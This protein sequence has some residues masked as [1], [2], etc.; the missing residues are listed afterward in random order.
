MKRSKKWNGFVNILCWNQSRFK[1]I[2]YRLEV[3]E[4]CLEMFGKLIICRVWYKSE[5]LRRFQSSTYNENQHLKYDYQWMLLGNVEVIIWM[6]CLVYAHCTSI[7]MLNWILCTVQQLQYHRHVQTAK[8]NE[9][10][11]TLH[12]SRSSNV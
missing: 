11:W 8:L 9:S 7:S 10:N 6:C 1:S 12:I 3:M 4:N 2:S 5:F